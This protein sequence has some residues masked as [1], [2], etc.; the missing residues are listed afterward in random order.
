[1]KSRLLTFFVAFFWLAIAQGQTIK[2]FS[3]TPAE[4]IKQ[5]QEFM[6]RAEVKEHSEMGKA[7][8]QVFQKNMSPDQQVQVISTTNRM[9]SRKM[10]VFP[11]FM[12]YMNANIQL[13][14]SPSFATKFDDWHLVLDTI[15]LKGGKEFSDFTKM[16][17][18]L[19][20]NNT[21][22]F[23][24]VTNGRFQPMITS[25]KSCPI[26]RSESLRKKLI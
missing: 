7:F 16:S 5:L 20:E 23:P 13:S 3:E 2:S 11:Y 1:M 12:N 8:I 26:K 6:D 24:L 22:F 21:I 25:F 14:K 17:I 4:Y 9:L 18:E 19:F 15:L 10:T